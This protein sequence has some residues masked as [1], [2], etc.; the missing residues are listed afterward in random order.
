MSSREPEGLFEAPG[1]PT[2]RL[3]SGDNEEFD[4]FVRWTGHM[5]VLAEGWTRY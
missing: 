5:P 2:A 3:L 4:G 1:I